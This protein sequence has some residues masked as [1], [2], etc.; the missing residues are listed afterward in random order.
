MQ[1]TNWFKFFCRSELLVWCLLIEIYW[2]TIDFLNWI[3]IKFKWKSSF[4][5]K[6]NRRT[7]TDIIRRASRWRRSSEPEGNSAN[8][9]KAEIF[10]LLRHSS[11][12]IYP[13]REYINV[14]YLLVDVL[15]FFPNTDEYQE[16]LHTQAP[17]RFL[18][19]NKK[20]FRISREAA[21]RKKHMSCSDIVS[22][23]RCVLTYRTAHKCGK[24]SFRSAST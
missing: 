8:L 1:A 6:I 2:T 20:Y 14:F 5:L 11:L 22:D 19:K 9:C 23:K 10:T 13:W 18:K 21:Q 17:E 16:L 15:L 4:E 24:N 7:V 3:M 12:C